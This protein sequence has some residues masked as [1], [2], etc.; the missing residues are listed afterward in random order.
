MQEASIRFPSCD[1]MWTSARTD[2]HFWPA[3]RQRDSVSRADE[4][5]RVFSRSRERRTSASVGRDGSNAGDAMGES[6]VV[7]V[8]MPSK[9]RSGN[10]EVT[11]AVIF[12]SIL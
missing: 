3:M 4:R 1:R 12:A 7:M 2:Q 6:S 5:R 10:G 8:K 11:S 9:G